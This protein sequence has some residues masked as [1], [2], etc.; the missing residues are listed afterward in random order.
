MTSDVSTIACANG[1]LTLSSADRG[2]IRRCAAAQSDRDDEQAC[3]IGD[4]QDPREGWPGAFISAYASSHPW[5]DFSE[6]FAPYL[7]MISVLD[8][9]THL[10]KSIRTN[11]RTRS[12]APLVERF[13]EVGVLVNEF[14]RTIGL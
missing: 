7:D 1:S 14:N 8:T 3:G 9:A 2:R 10:F 5:E 13:G 4:Q 6:M 12:V 11:L